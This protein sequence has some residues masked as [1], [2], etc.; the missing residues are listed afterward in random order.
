MG[1]TQLKMVLN[2]TDNFMSHVFNKINYYVYI[3]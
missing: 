1:Q 2:D 3:R